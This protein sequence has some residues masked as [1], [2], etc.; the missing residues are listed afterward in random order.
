MEHKQR[1]RIYIGISIIFLMGLL[2]GS[3]FDLPVAKSLYIE[4][5]IPAR[6]IS[7]VVAFAF[8]ES[9]VFFIGV[10][11]RHLLV[12]ME[13]RAKK[14]VITVIFIYLFI[15][16]ATLAGGEILN[17][18]LFG[19][20]FSGAAGSCTTACLPIRSGRMKLTGRCC[21]T[22]RRSTS[23]NTP[24]L[25]KWIPLPLRMCSCIWRQHTETSSGIRKLVI[26]NSGQNTTAG[27]AIRQTW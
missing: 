22:R 14:M 15:S 7:F 21:G 13:S 27:T 23:G 11:F 9:C 12:M 26:R 19:N 8:F 17:D 4:N 10:L 6:V 1:F 3:F 2:A 16:T 25:R 24:G 5:F 18:P 20:L